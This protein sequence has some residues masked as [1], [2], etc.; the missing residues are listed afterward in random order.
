MVGAQP[1]RRAGRPHPL[2]HDLTHRI[3][4]AQPGGQDGQR[5]LHRHEDQR[6]GQQGLGTKGGNHALR[7]RG[8]IQA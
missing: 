8:S 2:G 3:G 1:A 6:K 5:H 7:A 4:K